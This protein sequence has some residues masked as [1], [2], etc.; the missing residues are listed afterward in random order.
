MTARL[1]AAD[2]AREKAKETPRNQMEDDARMF[3]MTNSVKALMGQN[4]PKGLADRLSQPTDQEGLAEKMQA[5]DAD[6]TARRE[7]LQQD[8]KVATMCPP[9]PPSDAA[10][11]F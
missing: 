4:A 11:R 9:S 10:R 6:V 2:Q 5:R 8:K 1:A 7:K 3:D